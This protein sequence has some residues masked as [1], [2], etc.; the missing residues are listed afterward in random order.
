MCLCLYIS[1]KAQRER[2][3]EQEEKVAAQVAEVVEMKAEISRLRRALQETEG[4]YISKLEAED[5]YEEH[6]RHASVAI[7]FCVRE[8]R[9]SESVRRELLGDEKK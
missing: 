7:R 5:V 9:C 4:L 1:L 8:C 3:R 2:E 6:V